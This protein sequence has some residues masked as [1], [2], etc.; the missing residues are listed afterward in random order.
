MVVDRGTAGHQFDVLV[1]VDRALQGSCYSA[2]RSVCYGLADGRLILEGTVP[3]YFMKQ[4]AQ[5][6]VQQVADDQSI[7]NQIV[8]DSPTVRTPRRLKEIALA[9]QVA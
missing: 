1:A 2:I 3:S 9:E 7:D 5:T 4:V 6:I 8:V